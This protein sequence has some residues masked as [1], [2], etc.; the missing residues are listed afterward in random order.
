MAKRTRY[1]NRT[2]GRAGAKR[3]NRPAAPSPSALDRVRPAA[4]PTS[5]DD[6]LDPAPHTG[7]D[8][9]VRSAG[10]L[11]EAEIQRA[12]QLE[13]EATARERAAIAESLR[14]R[15][16]GQE[17]DLGE[18]R[19]ANAPLSVRAAHEY[20]YVARD[21]KRIALTASLMVAILAVL[22]VLVNVLGV[23]SL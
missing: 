14:R 17:R 2:S 23:I 18:A 6:V 8:M 12:A 11:T 22:H 16:R 10:G 5:L 9:P 7:T 20:A 1:S 21:V 15:S 3:S 19:D 13:A 4:R